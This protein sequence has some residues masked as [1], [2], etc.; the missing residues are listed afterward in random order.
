MKTLKSCLLAFAACSLVGCAAPGSPP[1][2]Q[3]QQNF[4]NA[5]GVGAQ[6]EQNR[7]YQRQYAPPPAQSVNTICRRNPVDGSVFCTSN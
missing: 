4:M 1:N 5:L 3:A 6:I 2:Y 7:N